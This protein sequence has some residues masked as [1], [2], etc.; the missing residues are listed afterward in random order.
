MERLRARWMRWMFFDS[1]LGAEKDWLCV[2]RAWMAGIVI[3]AFGEDIKAVM[4]I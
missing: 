3:L 2:P 1:S 4:H